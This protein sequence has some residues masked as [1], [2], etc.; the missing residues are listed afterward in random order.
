[1]KTKLVK[2]SAHHHEIL[3]RQAKAEDRTMRR[4]LERI[5][6]RLTGFD[7]VQPPPSPD[8]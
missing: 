6:E 8:G 1:M 4:T 5:I 7:S 2:V 3:A